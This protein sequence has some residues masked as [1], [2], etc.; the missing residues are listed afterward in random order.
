M[1]LLITSMLLFFSLVSYSQ[2]YAYSYKGKLTLEQQSALINE[3]N[4]LNY[5]K[6]VKCFQKEHGGEIQ[7]I[8]PVSTGH[9]ENQTPV[10]ITAIKEKMIALG[11][12]PSTFIELGN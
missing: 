10:T 12:E 11:C 1:K 8:I 3:L 2:H 4:A 5:F 9:S 7:F 6:D